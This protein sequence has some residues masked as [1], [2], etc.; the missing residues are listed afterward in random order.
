MF[1]YRKILLL[2]VVMLSC[3]REPSALTASVTN[4]DL[5]LGIV[6]VAGG[7]VA[8]YQRYRLLVCKYLS[9][10]SA[11]VFV[12]NSVCR[13]ALLTT[14][15]EEVDIVG[16]KYLA[17]QDK[18]HLSAAVEVRLVHLSPLQY[19]VLYRQHAA[20]ATVYVLG[21]IFTMGILAPIYVP[22]A[23]ISNK[24]A[25]KAL[26]GHSE[27]EKKEKQAIGD[28]ALR[29]IPSP[30][31]HTCGFHGCK[32][33]S[34]HNSDVITD[35]HWNNIFSSDFHAMTSLR[36]KTDLRAII[37]SVADFLQLRVNENALRLH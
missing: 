21:T 34:Y 35:K 17:G 36:N 18:V 6:P 8:K 11:G 28:K 20:A 15:G 29:T 25:E 1:I 22:L 23:I 4:G 5:V 37:T 13:S 2:W 10:Y 32:V 9:E 12:D 16:K 3:G 14:T 7:E 26:Q 24:K 19:H 31:S 33:A 27:N 30:A